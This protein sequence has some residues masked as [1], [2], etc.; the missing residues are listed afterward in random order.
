[1]QKDKGEETISVEEPTWRVLNPRGVKPTIKISAL[2]PRVSDLNDKVV[3]VIDSGIFGA[4][5]FTE[6]IAGLLPGHVPPVKVVY[7]KLAGLFLTEDS[8]IWDEVERNA[9][10]FIYGP[11]GGTNGFMTG[12][13]W[14]VFL[15]K[16]G[17]PGVYVL[18]QGFE[19]AVQKSCD[20]QGMPLLRRVVAPTPAWSEESLGRAEGILQ[21]II[22]GLTAPL[23]E[24]EQRTGEIVPENLPRRVM[25]G[26]SE[27]IQDYFDTRKWTD[28]LPIVPPTEKRVALM[29]SA[30]S[31]S[32]DEVLTD[33]MPP[34]RWVVTVERVAVNGVMAGCKPEAMPVLLALVEAYLKGK[35]DTSMMSANSWSLMVVVNGPIAK[36][37]GMNSGIH[38]MGPGNRANATIGRALRL[39]ITNLGGLTPGVNVMSCQGNP[40]NYS[41]AFAEN[42]EASPWDPLHVTRGYKREESCLTLF[43]GGWAHGGCMTGRQV[44]GEPLYLGGILEVL[45]TFQHPQG[46]VILLSPLLAKRIAREKGF[47]KKA[48][49]EYLW[50]NTLKTAREFRLDPHYTTF[51]EPGLRGEKNKHGASPW[52]SWYLTADDCEQVPV[53]GKSDF[54]YP[55]VVGGENHEDFQAWHMALPSTVSIDTWR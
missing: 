37:L 51:I 1:M 17:V 20:N 54:I 29:L 15:E 13:R 26:T 21:E 22:V 36:E 44:S 18:S 14:S 52:P 8:E 3:Y 19:K 38:A 16:K 28:G 6:K 47:D 25:E 4:Y 48:F 53:Y 7:R 12:A 2:C 24:E 10:A 55:V 43:D 32:A 39:L 27:E 9:D 49:Q 45:V 35:F 11:A 30:T 40:T 50:K 23:N 42:E 31:H 46:A 41:F 5:K 33:A 34:D